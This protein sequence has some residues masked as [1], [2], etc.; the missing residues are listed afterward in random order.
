[1]QVP[2]T[3]T[4]V[5]LSNRVLSDSLI[6]AGS[7]VASGSSD[8]LRY[9]IRD[10][11]TLVKIASQYRSLT[12]HYTFAEL[13]GDIRAAN[14]L[15][16]DLLRPGRTL[17]VPTGQVTAAPRVR[18]PVGEGIPLRGIYLPGATCASSTVF[19]RV[20]RFIAVGGNGVVLDGKDIDGGVTFASHQPLASWGADRRNP[21][22]SRL[23]ELIRR[24]HARRLYVAVRI[25][26]FLDGE[27]GR[28]RPD[29]ALRDTTQA[30]WTEKDLVW[31]DP[32][33]EEVREYNIGLAVELARA[34]V[35]EIQFD[36]VRFPTNGWP[37]GSA[38]DH[39]V[40]AAYR[41][42]VI[43]GFLRE[44]RLALQA[45]PVKIAADLFG[46]MAWDRT[47]D[48][49]ATG[50]HIPSIAEHVDILCPMVYPSH[51]RNGFSGVDR[52]ADHPQEF[53]AEG[54]RRFRGMTAGRTEI[55]PWL[56]AFA[57]GVDQ[58]DRHYVL[59]QVQGARSAGADGWCLW[60]PAGHYEVAL[61]ALAFLD[62]YPLLGLISQTTT[63]TLAQEGIAIPPDLIAPAAT[64]ERSPAKTGT[65]TP[66]E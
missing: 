53:V 32:A 22:I 55:R 9:I 58:Y 16:T 10:G 12:H 54:C 29:L 61:G 48:Q 63:A 62:R 39:E 6:A 25:A 59:A 66:R 40:A 34:G 4:P 35:D 8:T 13:V 18:S 36:Y 2:S 52:P 17:R 1:M 11:D 7:Q 14:G 27:L 41:R 50:Q 51:Y 46:V 28:R 42:A 3:A 60:N 30:V 38:G 5:Q 24:F 21:I 19:D 44:A 45:Y 33:A 26:C 64:A 56:Q 23:P 47:I 49:A 15:D 31:V 57:Y 43:S 20:D 65:T 37:G